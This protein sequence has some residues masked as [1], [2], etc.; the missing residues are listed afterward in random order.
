LAIQPRLHTTCSQSASF[1][2]TP[3]SRYGRYRLDGAIEEH[4]WRY[5]LDVL[6]KKA[7]LL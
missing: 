1:P 2:N 3:P 5:R 7:E 4:W 6:V